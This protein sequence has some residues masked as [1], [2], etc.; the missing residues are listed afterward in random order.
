[1]LKTIMSNFHLEKIFWIF[2]KK[3]KIMI[4][5]ALIGGILGGG[6]A[7]VTRTST[8][9]AKIYFYVYTNP[10]YITDSGVNLSS[11]EIS[12]ASNLLKSYMQILQST[13]FLNQVIS[14]LNLSE[15]GYTAAKLKKNM[16]SA[17]VSS[18]AVFYVTI[19]NGTR[20]L[21]WRLPT[22][23]VTW[24]RMSLPGL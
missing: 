3:L 23:L 12:Q 16:G 14:E 15:Q 6:F 2:R 5:F 13:S 11:S 22:R 10:D 20:F 21:P 1:M 18:T 19:Y 9:Q 4:L 8:Y 7:F 24:L 17:A